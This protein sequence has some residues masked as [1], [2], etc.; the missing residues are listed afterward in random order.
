[1]RYA[2]EIEVPKP[3]DE[4]F[5]YLADF[6]HT[7]E[8]DPGIAEARRLTPAPTAG[9]SRFEVVALFRGKRQR[10]EYVVTAYEEGRRIALRGEGEKAISDDVIVV[11]P[12]NGGTRIGYEADL[13]LKGVL[14]VAEPF[15]RSTVERMG[16]DAL[17]GLAARLAR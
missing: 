9:G 3:V 15:L 14:R 6:T 4:T 17:D 12:S 13:R 8:W 1:M 7:A 2:R 5:A 10:F 16:N 11:S